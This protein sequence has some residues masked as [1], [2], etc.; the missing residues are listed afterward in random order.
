MAD[1]ACL[2]ELIGLEPGTSVVELGCVGSEMV[3]VARH[4][5]AAGR[6]FGID[7][8][9]EMIE[10]ARQ[11]VIKAG[12]ACG[13]IAFRVAPFGRLPHPKNFADVLLA[14]CAGDLEVDRDLVLR[15]IFRIMRPG[16]RLIL[17]DLVVTAEVNKVGR[18]VGLLTEADYL[19]VLAGM[20][21][22][23]LETL[24]RQDLTP[25][26]TDDSGLEA[27]SKP[28]LFVFSATKPPLNC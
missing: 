18:S 6:V 16:A 7:S 3:R 25:S 23:G 2:S 17:S 19:A 14:N 11:A 20:S 8:A 1:E 9:Q 24:K 21:F 22:T 4:V 15:N 26:E 28:A 13:N 5:G 12:P 27:E 10:L